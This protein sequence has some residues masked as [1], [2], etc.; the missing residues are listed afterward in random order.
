MFMIESSVLAFGFGLLGMAIGAAIVLVLGYF[1]IPAVS[2]EL[3]FIFAGP[4]LYPILTVG[5]MTAAFVVVFLVSVAST[6]YPARLATRIEPVI[7][8]GKED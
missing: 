7:A 5:Q 1:G 4:R 6:V 8:M 3:Y 2:D